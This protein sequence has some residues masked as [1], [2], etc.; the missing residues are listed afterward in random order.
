[1]ASQFPSEFLGFFHL[2][3]MFRSLTIFQ[4][5]V[6][7]VLIPVFAQVVLI[8]TLIQSMREDRDAQKWTAHSKQVI[9]KVEGAYRLLLEAYAGVRNLVVLEEPIRDDPFLR[10]LDKAP[11]ALLELRE[12]VADNRQQQDRVDDLAAHGRDYSAVIG[13]TKQLVKEDERAGAARR[14]DEA[15]R[16]LKL[17]R[18]KVEIAIESTFTQGTA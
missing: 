1:M 18:S 13:S 15:G 10:A 12:L 6:L 2:G 7:I 3:L 5:G 14:L 16:S 17:I 8:G 11:R 9:A 4:K